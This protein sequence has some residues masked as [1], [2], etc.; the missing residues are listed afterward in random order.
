LEYLKVHG[1]ESMLEPD[2]PWRV[3]YAPR[4]WSNLVEHLQAKGFAYGTFFRAWLMDWTEHGEAIDR[5]RDKLMLLARDRRLSGVGFVG[6]GPDGDARSVSPMTAIH[7]PARVLV[8][9]EEQRE[10]LDRGAVLVIVDGPMDAIAVSNAGRQ[11]AGSWA[12]IPLCGG[13]LSSSQAKTL[14]DLSVSDKVIVAIGGT[15]GERNQ[16]ASDLLDLASF[17]DKV[18]GIEVPPRES[19]AGLAQREFAA[20]RLNDVL[21]KSRP[22]MTY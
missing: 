2:S 5:H 16:S 1:A 13:G 11:A 21:R 3:G 15:Q 17:F 8:G 22:L 7:R 9:I 6:I 14:R 18:R 20:E 12:A 4:T 10:L 19:L